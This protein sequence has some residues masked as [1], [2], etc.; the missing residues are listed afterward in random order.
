MINSAL[1]QATGLDPTE[2]LA[3]LD[4]LVKESART[5]WG[6]TRNEM[7]ADKRLYPLFQGFGRSAIDDSTYFY[8][9]P[10]RALHARSARSPA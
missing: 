4:R 6:A 8:L 1:R 10:Q 2:S 7:P 3:T 5:D 9:G